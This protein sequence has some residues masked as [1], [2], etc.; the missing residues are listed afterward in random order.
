MGCNRCGKQ[1][2]RRLCKNCSLAEEW[3]DE[4]DGIEDGDDE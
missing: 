4:F 1:T 2:S 3:E